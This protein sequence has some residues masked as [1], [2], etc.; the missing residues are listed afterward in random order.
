[1]G[2]YSANW[3]STTYSLFL[4]IPTSIGK[5]LSRICRMCSGTL[6]ISGWGNLKGLSSPWKTNNVQVNNAEFS[7]T[8]TIDYSLKIAKKMR[9][10]TSS[11][12]FERTKAPFQSASIYLEYNLLGTLK[13]KFSFLK[14]KLILVLIDGRECLCNP[15]SSCLHSLFMKL[16][17]N[18]FS[19]FL[20]TV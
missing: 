4:L 16:T 15:M 5:G 11:S 7:D 13:E 12:R 14:E 19:S 18:S 3:L 17:K 8:K 6:N 9:E 20:R 10:N 1:M 2:C